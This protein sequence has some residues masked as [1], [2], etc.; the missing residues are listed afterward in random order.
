MLCMSFLSLPMEL[1][2]VGLPDWWVAFKNSL[3]DLL[4]SG[5]LGPPYIQV[6]IPTDILSDMRF[7]TI[8]KLFY[9]Y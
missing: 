3:V 7:Q 9:A 2:F 1:G 4:N 5:S 8:Q 6:E